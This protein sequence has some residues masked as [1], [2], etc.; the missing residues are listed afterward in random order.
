MN[1][2]PNGCFWKE[3]YNGINTVLGL[4]NPVNKITA[5]SSIAIA[6]F[7]GR[8]S[9]LSDDW[10]NGCF[11]PF[12]WDEETAVK[13]NVFSFYKGSSVVRHSFGGSLQVFGT[14]FMDST[15]TIDNGGIE[16]L[17]HEWGHSVQE[18]I[19]GP[20]YLINIALPS[21]VYYWYDVKTGGTSK[22]Y[23]STPWERTADWFGGVTRSYGYKEGG[24]G[25]GYC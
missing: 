12:N 22:S 8:W 15:E 10:Q 1:I 13:A 14:I 21:G 24:I 16:T 6:M 20:A 25:M 18:N 5:I 7:Q 23:Y 9:E 3:L 2:D 17:N 4:L 19:L 11:N